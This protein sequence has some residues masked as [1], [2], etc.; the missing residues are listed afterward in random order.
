MLSLFLFK[1][2]NIIINNFQFVNI[3]FNLNIEFYNLYD[4]LIVENEAVANGLD[5][6]CHK[7]PQLRFEL[8][9]FKVS[10]FYVNS[11]VLIHLV[12]A[13]GVKLVSGLFL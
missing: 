6:I 3:L 2:F 9:L 13:H 11:M 5:A 1:V 12:E 7:L 8:V 10:V 4:L